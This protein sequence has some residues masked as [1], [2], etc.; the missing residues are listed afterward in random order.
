MFEYANISIFCNEFVVFINALSEII[1]FF[2]VYKN[3]NPDFFP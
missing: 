1:G 2:N 3:K